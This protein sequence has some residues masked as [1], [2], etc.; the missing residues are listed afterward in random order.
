ML[1]GPQTSG[2]FSFLSLPTY[3][4]HTEVTCVCPTD[5]CL[6]ISN[7]GSYK[8][9]IHKLNYLL[10]PA[11]YCLLG[12]D[13]SESLWVIYSIEKHFVIYLLHVFLL[14]TCSWGGQN[15]SL[16][17][18]QQGLHQSWNFILCIL[19][20]ILVVKLLFFLMAFYVFSIIKR[21]FICRGEHTCGGMSE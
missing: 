14:T 11:F 7:S 15:L 13:S 10:A 12:S 18:R 2:C 8:S 20:F 21:L 4:R 1:V 3:C 17:N 5:L 6:W 19:S 16:E 9:S